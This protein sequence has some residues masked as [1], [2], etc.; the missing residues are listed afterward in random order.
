MKQDKI[1]IFQINKVLMDNMWASNHK[2]DN[3]K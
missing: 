1:L 2:N 3:Y